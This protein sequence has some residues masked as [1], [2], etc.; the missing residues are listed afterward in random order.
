MPGGNVEDISMQPGN[1]ELE[2]VW[3]QDPTSS[4]VKGNRKPG[5]MKAD[6]DVCPGQTTRLSELSSPSTIGRQ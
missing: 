5:K 6:T 3:S 2:S 4:C 1:W